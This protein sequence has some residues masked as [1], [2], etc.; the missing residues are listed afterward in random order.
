M[1]GSALPCRVPSV[2]LE[3][4]RGRSD[5]CARAGGWSPAGSRPEKVM[6][7]RRVQRQGPAVSWSRAAS[8]HLAEAREPVRELRT[9]SPHV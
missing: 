6:S 2:G 1:A 4:S 5:T 8:P 9:P 7:C 3:A